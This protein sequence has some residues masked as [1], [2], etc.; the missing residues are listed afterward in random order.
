MF[1]MIVIVYRDMG[2]AFGG[3]AWRIARGFVGDGYVVYMA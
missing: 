3:W 2:G 1:E